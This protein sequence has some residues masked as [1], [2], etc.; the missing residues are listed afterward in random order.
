[1]NKTI[2]ILVMPDGKTK[3]ETHGYTGSACRDASRFLEE[4]MGVGTV[5][6]LKHEY[7]IDDHTTHQQEEELQC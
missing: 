6:R 5:E 4:A 7:F 1:M 2:T 3:I